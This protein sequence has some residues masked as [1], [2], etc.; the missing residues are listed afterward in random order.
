MSRR[1]LI[2]KMEDR[3]QIILCGRMRSGGRTRRGR[4]RDRTTIRHQTSSGGVRSQGGPVSL[5]EEDQRYDEGGG[6]EL[7]QKQHVAFSQMSVYRSASESR[8]HFVGHI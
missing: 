2:G 1:A 8:K 5:R 6:V 7:L 3:V 4:I